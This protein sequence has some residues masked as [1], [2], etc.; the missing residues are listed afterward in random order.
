MRDVPSNREQQTILKEVNLKMSKLSEGL[1]RFVESMSFS[2]KLIKKADNT[3]IRESLKKIPSKLLE[4]VDSEVAEG[5]WVPI[6]HF[7]NY[8]NGNNRVYNTALWNNVIKNQE[9]TWK[10]SP[11][12]TDHPEGDSD[13]NP[14][15]ICGVWLD[16]KMGEPNHEGVG[17]VYG[18]LVP[19]G[20]LGEDLKD[21]LKK[22]LRVGTSSSGFGRLLSDGVTVDPDTYRIERLADFVLTPSQSTY[23]SWDESS[24]NVVDSTREEDNSIYE[25]N[26][27]YGKYSF[28]FGERKDNKSNIK[29]N[30][31]VKDSKITKLE[32]K[33]FR[34]DMMSFLESA[35]SIKDPQERLEEFK[36]I[37]DYLE[38]GI[39]PDLKEKVEQKIKEEEESIKRILKESVSMKEELGIESLKDLKGK[40]TEV[41]ENTI[42]AEREAK[43]WKAI[44]EKLTEQVKDLT[45]K[46]ESR[47]TNEYANYLKNKVESLTEKINE[48]DTQSVDVI[49]TISESYDSIKKAYE[50][51]K[52]ENKSLKEKNKA[53]VN[54]VNTLNK[55]LKESANRGISLSRKLKDTTE[56]LK[57]SNKKCNKL[58]IMLDN[59]KEKYRES[60]HNLDNTKGI[61]ENMRKNLMEL[62]R[63][64]RMNEAR[65]KRDY[66]EKKN[67]LKEQRAIER[68]NN[69]SDSEKYFEYLREQ[70]GSE[71]DAY[72]EK[73][74]SFRSLSEA[75]Q[76]FLT[77]V[78]NNLKESVEIQNSYIPPYAVNNADEQAMR[79]NEKAFYRD[80]IIDR[81]PKGW[82]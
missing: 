14:R 66:L 76:F 27:A 36:D 51:L 9:E 17:I 57:E 19:S 46:C 65:I 11:M 60:L 74:S 35:E 1:E 44:S 52:K 82:K 31:V 7:G 2:N 23:F 3:V 63:K 38:E 32:E 70:Y 37:R 10:G 29:E 54:K 55:T 25:S 64:E 20:R 69:L 39:C 68:A 28:A 34:R 61:N 45:K 18:L 12:L 16:C 6:S 53:L 42:L 5:W 8:K 80:T 79:I 33:K 48:H 15:D 58:S 78:L 75:K 67:L 41:C 13:G 72:K 47:P 77:Q 30:V 50:S 73:F 62:E 22:G 40:L 43:D 4:S 26:S 24:S 59:E 71:M 21:H 56:D 81:K 49:K